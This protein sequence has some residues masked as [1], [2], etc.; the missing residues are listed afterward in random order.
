[1]GAL[2]ARTGRN[3]QPRSRE[4]SGVR[5]AFAASRPCPQCFGTRFKIDAGAWQSRYHCPQ[6]KL[7]RLVLAQN[8]ES[9]L[10]RTNLTGLLH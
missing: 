7:A 2:L 1:M 9:L 8:V 3:F 5:H 6:G 4:M 10:P